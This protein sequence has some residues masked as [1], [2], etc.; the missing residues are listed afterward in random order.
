ME[1]YTSHLP[2]AAQNLQK[3]EDAP[4]TVSKPCACGIPAGASREV[5]R[6][7]KERV[8]SFINRPFGA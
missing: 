6:F 3:K 2:E 1:S 5:S 8:Q 4:D 7:P